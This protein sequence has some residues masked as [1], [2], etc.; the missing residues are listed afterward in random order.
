MVPGEIIW[1]R[2]LAARGALENATAVVF[3]DKAA[4][5]ILST[6]DKGKVHHRAAVARVH[7]RRLEAT[8]RGPEGR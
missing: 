2:Y 7:Q 4:L 5:R 6:A 3:P 1:M 8:T